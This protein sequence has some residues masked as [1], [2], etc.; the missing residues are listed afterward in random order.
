MPPRNLSLVPPA[1]P[2]QH[3]SV[4]QLR[5]YAAGTLLPAQQHLVEAH[6]I[7]CA[8]C[9]EILDGLSAT[10]YATT[11]TAL[12]TVQGRL[13]ARLAIDAARHSHR[14]AAWAG[15]A[16]TLLLLTV[17]ASV[18]WLNLQHP[19]QQRNRVA[20]NS[21]AAPKAAP[22]ADSAPIPAQVQAGPTKPVA[23]AARETSGAAHAA[24]AETGLTPAQGTYRPSAQ[25][26]RVAVAA[27]VRAATT[28]QSAAPISSG[29]SSSSPTLASAA[30][31]TPIASASTSSTAE[32][33]P[34]PATTAD[35]V[36]AMAPRASTVLEIKELPSPVLAAVPVSTVVLASIDTPTEAAEVAI[37]ADKV[38]ASS[39]PALAPVKSATS[40][41]G[42]SAMRMPPSP[43]LASVPSGGHAAFRRYLK[44]ELKFP[45]AD[46][47]KGVE[48]VV[49]LRFVVAA[50]GSLQDIKVVSPVSEA[51]DA[52]AIRLLKEGP[53]WYP[54]IV[55]GKRVPTVMRVSVTFNPLE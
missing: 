47:A 3:I 5:Q 54:A 15:V 10:D 41:E 29:L 17:A 19:P 34:L 49:K 38:R 32:N 28:K 1:T 42:R 50:D 52:E 22:P 51:C 27:A 43:D 31:A 16:A 46:R 6:T 14:Y 7:D 36:T 11:E 25:P 8:Y 12:R 33:S 23:S 37:P 40:A 48:G 55:R 18:F 39:S 35:A 9:G 53:A 13:H 24:G 21:A 4:E 45:E 30:T 44:K 2:D 20:A 26:A